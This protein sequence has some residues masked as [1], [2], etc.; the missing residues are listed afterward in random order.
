M[1]L[2][3]HLHA[4]NHTWTSAWVRNG[5]LLKATLQP[6][7]LWCLHKHK[8][9]CVACS[10]IK[11]GGRTLICP[12]VVGEVKSVWLKH[13]LIIACMDSEFGNKRKICGLNLCIGWPGSISCSL[14][15][16]YFP[17]SLEKGKGHHP[18]P[19]DCFLML[20]PNGLI[21]SSSV[22]SILGIIIASLLGTEISLSVLS[23][24]I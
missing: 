1:A 11:Q 5:L 21:Q 15:C 7:L 24:G 20:C 2:S 22:Y 8:S 19:L 10:H 18:S 3:F 23:N 9:I 6:P 13:G 16:A 14:S 4:R 17:V 12:N